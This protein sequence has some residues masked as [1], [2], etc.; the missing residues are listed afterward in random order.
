MLR[1]GVGA[2]VDTAVDT[3]VSEH[4]FGML[5]REPRVGAHHLGLNPQAELHAA[6]HHRIGQRVQAGWPTLR[7]NRPVAESSAVIGAAGEP[8]VVEH[9]PLDAQVSGGVDERKQ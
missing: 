9:E 3:A 2:A 7:V 1:L 4:P 8:A 5:A 6:G